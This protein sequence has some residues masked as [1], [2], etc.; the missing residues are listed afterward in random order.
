ML[1]FNVMFESNAFVSPKFVWYTLYTVHKHDTN[2]LKFKKFKKAP[3]V[4]KIPT[5]IGN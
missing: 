4:G 2:K 1:C 5:V 3:K